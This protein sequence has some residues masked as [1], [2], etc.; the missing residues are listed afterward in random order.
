MKF[1][2][3]Y[4]MAMWLLILKGLDIK[5]FAEWGWWIV[6]VL[7]TWPS[8]PEIV[9]F[10]MKQQRRLVTSVLIVARRKLHDVAVWFDTARKQP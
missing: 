9:A 3:W 10:L 5:P 7:I 4:G 1:G 2:V 8:L 6:L